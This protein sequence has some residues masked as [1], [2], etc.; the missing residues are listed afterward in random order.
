MKAEWRDFLKDNGAEFEEETD[1]INHFGN[2]VREQRVSLNGNVFSP[3]TQYGLIAIYGNDAQS[4]LQSQFSN[5]SKQITE[6]QSQMSSYCNPQGRVLALFQVFFHKDTY[7]LILPKDNIEDTLK[8]LQMFVLRSQVH[9]ADASDDISGLGVAGPQIEAEL[10]EILGDIPKDL[11]AVKTIK[12]ITVICL[13]KHRFMLYA[14]RADLEKL[15]EKLLVRCA[16]VGPQAWELLNILAGIPQ[17]Y[18]VNRDQFIPQML[19]LDDL[20]AINFEKGCY[21]GQEI[22]ARTKYLGKIK[23]RLYRI[24]INSDTSIAMGSSLYTDGQVSGQIVTV[25]FNPDGGYKAL[26]VLYVEHV[27]KQWTVEAAE[28]IVEKHE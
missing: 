9:L 14:H 22:V 28:V 23:R 17:I 5:D 8:R 7:Y 11:Y 26:A 2:P 24:Q 15:W 3:L 19:N 25:A 20:N 16:P 4:F 21:P 27:N 10:M 12:D 13:E 6:N 1:I 18:H